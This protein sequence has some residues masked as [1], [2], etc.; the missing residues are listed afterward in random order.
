MPT[1]PEIEALLNELLAA[2]RSPGYGVAVRDVASDPPTIHVDFRYLSGHTYCC[3][4]PGCHLP[5]DLSR[6]PRLSGFTIRW[7][8]IVEQGAQ[9]KCL[10]K[11]GLPLDSDGYEYEFAT[12]GSS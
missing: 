9:L 1:K 2:N 11:L 10:A 7:H 5:C 4:E 3:A 8:C 6:L 12:V